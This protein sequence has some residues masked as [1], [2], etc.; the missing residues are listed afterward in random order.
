VTHDNAKPA[1]LAETAAARSERREELLEK[2]WVAEA[3]AVLATLAS[4]N[5]SASDLQAARAFLR[6]NDVSRSTLA[7]FRR[8]RGGPFGPSWTP[9][10][11]DDDD[12]AEFSKDSASDPAL[13]NVQPFAPALPPPRDTE[14]IDD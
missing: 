14:T 2:I 4:K 8:S 3:E 11:F 7:Q 12:S 10:A 13:R 9:P 5:P 6:D 1:A